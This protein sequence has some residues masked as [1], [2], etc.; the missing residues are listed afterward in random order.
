MYHMWWIFMCWVTA[1]YVPA[2]VVLRWPNSRLGSKVHMLSSRIVSSHNAFVFNHIY[3]S[4]IKT[5]ICT[6]VVF[7]SASNLNLKYDV[8]VAT[9]FVKPSSQ[10]TENHQQLLSQ[11]QRIPTAHCPSCIP[12]T[13][14]TLYTFVTTFCTL[15]TCN[16]S[17]HCMSL[18]W[19][20]GWVSR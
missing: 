2:F 14:N 17:K 19:L 8:E 10:S 12:C 3:R 5:W 18:A 9:R 16:H 15:Y 11:T 1:K 13:W 6:V 4:W 20:Q 7:G